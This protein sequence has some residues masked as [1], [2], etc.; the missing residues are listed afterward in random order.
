[1]RWS[2]I[3]LNNIREQYRDSMATI[4][5]YHWNT[6]NAAK[7]EYEALCRYSEAISKKP[8]YGNLPK[9]MHNMTF[10]DAVTGKDIFYYQKEL[11]VAECKE[12]TF[13]HKN[14]QYQWLLTEAY[15]EFEDYLVNLYAYCGT[16]NNKVWPQKDYENLPPVNMSNNNFERHLD[17][18]KNKKKHKIPHEVL[19]RFRSVFNEL[20]SIETNN[21]LQVNIALAFALIEKLRHHIVHKSGRI[22][23][24]EVFIKEVSEK[25]GLYNNGNVAA[26]NLNL[27]KACMGINRFENHIILLEFNPDKDFPFTE[28][29]MFKVLKGILMAYAWL[30]FK[31]AGNCTA[32]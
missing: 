4:E 25:V 10:K 26:E 11:T 9:S 23:D 5:V 1:M 3:Q 22:N 30:L 17:F 19:N 27:I 14:K 8:E 12:I 13:L 28:Y 29:S 18:I 15:E 21:K 24:A 2:A 7:K 32:K 16:H 6:K 31:F 20:G